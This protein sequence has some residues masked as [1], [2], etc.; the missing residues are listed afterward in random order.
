[1][2]A[3]IWTDY[4][5]DVE[6]LQGGDQ[7]VTEESSM[8]CI[9]E[10]EEEHPSTLEELLPGAPRAYLALCRDVRSFPSSSCRS[11]KDLY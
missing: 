2:F 4:V 10:L 8:R 5:R 9:A 11:L 7:S 3:P 1:M 6:L